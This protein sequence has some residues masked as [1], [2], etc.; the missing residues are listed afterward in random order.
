MNEQPESHEALPEDLRAIGDAVSRMPTPPPPADL[1]A[2]TMNRIQAGEREPRRSSIRAGVSR[3][4]VWLKPITSPAGRVAAA[5]LLVGTLALLTNP[6]TSERLGRMVEGVIGT[7]TTDRIEGVVD[8]MLDAVGPAKVPGADYD[9]A[10]AEDRNRAPT[11]HKNPN[12]RDM[13]RTALPAER[14]SA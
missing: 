9:W 2:R 13:P 8:K 4:S 10:L 14:Q 12:N 5:F 11:P 6:I 3:L 1:A 7:R